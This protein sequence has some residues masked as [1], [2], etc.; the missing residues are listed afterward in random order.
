[1]YSFLRSFLADH[2]PPR[3]ELPGH[4]RGKEEEEYEEEYE[5][6]KEGQSGDR[7]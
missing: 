2:I 4:Q 7:G 5:E 1:M 6:E 3:L